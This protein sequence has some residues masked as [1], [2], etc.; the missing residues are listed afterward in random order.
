MAEH[1]NFQV[2]IVGRSNPPPEKSNIMKR[3][4]YLYEQIYSMDNLILAE[5]KA[6]R[7]KKR[8]GHLPYGI[9]RFDK[10]RTEYLQKLQKT[11]IEGTFKTSEYKI[12]TIKADHG[13]ER[14]IFKLPYYPDRILHHAILNVIAPYLTRYMIYDSYAC[15][16]GKGT[17]FGVKRVQ[18][19]LKDRKGTEWFLKLDIKK[20]YPTIDQDVT[21]QLLGRIFKDSSTSPGLPIGLYTS[22]P[23][24]NYVLSPMDHYIKETLK[25]KYYFRYCDDMVFMSD[26]KE[27]LQEVYIRVKEM[28]ENK[29]HQR[30]HDNYI[31]SRV[32]EPIPHEKI[33][34]RRERSADRLSGLSVHTRKDATQKE[35][36]N[37]I[38]TQDGES[39]IRITK[40][41]NPCKL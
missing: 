19:S 39:K 15:V 11:L 37:E 10:H 21:M 32:G 6:R 22:Q 38:C 13:K 1:N 12:M 7:N 26:S 20:F 31:L 33:Y 27:K 29:Y 35:H 16:E 28:I 9:K 41:R 17:T 24:A 2:A 8:N 40:E 36:E 30:L 18:Q 14:E 4:G 34:R 23:L 5:E 3:I 25:V